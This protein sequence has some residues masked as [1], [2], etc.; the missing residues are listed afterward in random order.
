MLNRTGGANPPGRTLQLAAVQLALS[1]DSPSA[2]LR[3]ALGAMRRAAEVNP[4][5][6]VIVLPAFMGFDARGRIVDDPP[7]PAA[8][9]PIAALAEAARELG[10]FVAL[11]VADGGAGGPFASAVLLDRDG[12]IAMTQ[13]QR[14]IAR[15]ERIK[16]GRAIVVRATLL[17]RIALLMRDDLVDVELWHEARTAGAELVFGCMALAQDAQASRDGSDLASA[18]S[19]LA[20]VARSA[21]MWAAIADTARDTAAGSGA[22]SATCIVGPNGVIRSGPTGGAA[23]LYTATIVME[24]G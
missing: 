22:A 8:S 10:V 18:W 17:G 21:G 11:G 3:A 19:T 5:P 9:P 6:D 15:D 20:Y 12:D 16:P 7:E 14:R 2:N 4:A 13:H 24:P 23:Q 1:P